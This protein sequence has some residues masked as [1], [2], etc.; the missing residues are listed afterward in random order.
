MPHRSRDENDNAPGTLPDL[1]EHLLIGRRYR[2]IMAALVKDQGGPDRLAEAR[3]QLIRRYA[4]VA[5]L[6]EQMESR[7][8]RGGAIRVAEHA[9]LCGSLVR[10][11]QIIGLDPKTRELTP[12]LENYLRSTQQELKQ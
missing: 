6:A 10:L 11:A 9:L 3:L 7:M 1:E 12:T 4:A 2:E 5:V 8:L